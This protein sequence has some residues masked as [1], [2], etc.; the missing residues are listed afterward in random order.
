MMEHH[1]LPLAMLELIS[2]DPDF[3]KH[4][5]RNQYDEASLWYQILCNILNNKECFLC[6]ELRSKR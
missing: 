6:I 4:V 1:I 5:L 3:P 2:N